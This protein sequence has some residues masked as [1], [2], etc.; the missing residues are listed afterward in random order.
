MGIDQHNNAVL[1]SKTVVALVAFLQWSVTRQVT[2]SSHTSTISG[3][4]KGRPSENGAA[5]LGMEASV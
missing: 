2:F 4:K 1:I 3:T 5:L